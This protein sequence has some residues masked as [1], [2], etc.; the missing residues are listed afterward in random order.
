MAT[1]RQLRLSGARARDLAAAV[2]EGRLHRSRRGRYRLASLETHAAQAHRMSAVLSHRSAA[3]QHE[4]A[5][6]NAPELPEVV[7]PR[8]RNVCAQ[9]QR[10]AVVR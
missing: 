2:R 7:V 3:V 5:V 8:N 6:K 9:D 1:T 4:W 10:T